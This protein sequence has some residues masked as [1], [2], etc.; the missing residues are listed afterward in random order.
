MPQNVQKMCS[1]ANFLKIKTHI[2]CSITPPEYRTFYEIMSKND[3]EPEV[4]DDVTVWRIRVG[5]WISKIIRMN[6]PTLPGS[7]PHTHVRARTHTH[8]HTDK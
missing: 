1:I 7:H 3:M 4:T 8:T 6:T 2:L 5:C